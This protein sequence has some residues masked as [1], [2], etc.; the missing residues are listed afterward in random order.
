MIRA[1]RKRPSRSA[2]AVPSH[3]GRKVNK[4]YT[5]RE[6]DV[7]KTIEK[8][9]IPSTRTLTANEMFQIYE[10]AKEN[11]NDLDMISMAFNFG[12]AVGHRGGMR[13]AKT[14]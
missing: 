4:L 12:Y 3:I 9:E 7:K 11:G 10:I 5:M 2:P 13:D 1:K 14:K 6:R 8:N